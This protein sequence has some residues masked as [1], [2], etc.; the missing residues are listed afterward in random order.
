MCRKVFTSERS[1]LHA[2]NMNSRSRPYYWPLERHMHRCYTY[3]WYVCIL[4]LVI[5]Y[6]YRCLESTPNSSLPHPENEYQWNVN[7]CRCCVLCN[8]RGNRLLIVINVVLTALI[9]KKAS[10]MPA[11]ASWKLASKEHQWF[12]AL[13]HGWWTWDVTGIMYKRSFDCFCKLKRPTNTMLQLGK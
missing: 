9:G 6:H 8:L 5:K 4:R 11:A 7:D 13:N 12:L 1:I 3:Q 2:T 10:N